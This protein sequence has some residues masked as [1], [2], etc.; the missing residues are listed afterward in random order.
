MDELETLP[1]IDELRKTIMSLSCGK[2]PGNEGM[3][4]EVVKTVT[5]NYFIGHLHGLLLQCREKATIAQDIRDAKIVTLY[6]NKG[7]HSDCN[8]YCGI[9]LLSIIG[10]AFTWVVL[11][12][13]QL[14][15]DWE[16]PESECGFRAE[17]S[18]IGKV[19]SLRQLHEKCC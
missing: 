19:S 4:P 17:Q 10:K 14:Q 1:T 11:N 12:H 18:I 3:P 7:S 9:A 13:L 6:K 8:K 2:A 5:E 15:A 16:Y